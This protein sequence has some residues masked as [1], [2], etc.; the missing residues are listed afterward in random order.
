M[1][2]NIVVAIVSA[3]SATIIGIT[4]LVLNNGRF[5]DIGNRF[6]DMGQTM[7][8]RFNDMNTRFSDMNTRFNDM[9]KRMDSLESSLGGRMDRIEHVLDVIQA[10]LKQFYRD[11][12]RLKEKTGLE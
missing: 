3:S 11:I 2:S 10:D 6:N 8:G 9:N 5:T 7:D 12:T 4:A 1:D